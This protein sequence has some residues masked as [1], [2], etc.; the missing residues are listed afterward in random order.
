MIDLLVLFALPAFLIPLS[1]FRLTL[2]FSR[3]RLAA[4]GACAAIY[5]A[6]ILVALVSAPMPDSFCEVMP[7]SPAA[8]RGWTPGIAPPA[9]S[10]PV[11]SSIPSRWWTGLTGHAELEIYGG[12]RRSCSAP[13][14]SFSPH[15]FLEN[16]WPGRKA[17]MRIE[18]F[19]GQRVKTRK[20]ILDILAGLPQDG[21]VSVRVYKSN[22]DSDLFQLIFPLMH[23]QGLPQWPARRAT[24]MGLGGPGLTV[25]WSERSEFTKGHRVFGLPGSPPVFEPT[26][27]AT[28]IAGAKDPVMSTWTM[29]DGIHRSDRPPAVILL[30]PAFVHS[31]RMTDSLLLDFPL[32]LAGQAVRI[33]LAPENLLRLWRVRDSIPKQWYAIDHSPVFTFSY[34]F[35]R[36][37]TLAFAASVFFLLLHLA[38]ARIWRMNRRFVPP[39]AGIFSLIILVAEIFSVAKIVF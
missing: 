19:Q 30:W 3:P 33:V 12:A 18:S 10:A 37:A 23:E 17:G 1:A 5:L 13:V 28:Q 29:P 4:A 11:G 21:V 8:A 25:S 38:E 14:F 34:L 31:P 20:D 15:M 16:Q 35:F 27:L 6:C 9:G 26:S 39:A 36:L 7:G 22:P 24:M 2:G 32:A